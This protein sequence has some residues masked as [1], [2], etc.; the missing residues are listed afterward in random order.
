M[1]MRFALVC[2]YRNFYYP[3]SEPPHIMAWW[4]GESWERMV[5]KRMQVEEAGYP[6]GGMDFWIV[7]LD[8]RA[9]LWWC[10]T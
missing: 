5:L 2:T 7:R 8:L 3:R 6:L 4:Y 9:P 1:P 10:I